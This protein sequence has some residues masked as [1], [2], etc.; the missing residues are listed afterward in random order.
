MNNLLFELKRSLVELDLGLKGDLG[1]SEAMEALMYSLFDDKV[2]AKWNKV[3]Y[4]SMRGLTTWLADALARQRQLEAWTADLALPKVTWLAGFFNAQAFLTAVMQVTARRNELPLDRLTTITDVTKKMTADE[5]ESISRDGAY[6]SGLFM[7]G[8]R[9]DTG[10]GQIE[11]AILKQL[12]SPSALATSRSFPPLTC[13]V[14][15]CSPADTLL[16]S[17]PPVL[18]SSR[19]P[20]IPS[21][22]HPV[23]PSPFIPSSHHPSSR[24]QKVQTPPLTPHV[25]P[26][27]PSRS[28]GHPRESGHGRQGRPRQLRVP[29]V[30]D[31]HAQ[32]RR[33]QA[34]RRLHLYR[35]PEDQAAGKQVVRESDASFQTRAPFAR[36]LILNPYV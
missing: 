32:P 12:Y 36:C 28:A 16:F 35:G 8:A 30:Q 27:L 26:P 1:M 5:I 29:R 10:T 7:E 15:P 19:H 22:R 13:P 11:D 24:E 9:W 17:R 2:P 25:R 3:A 20:V 23:I 33:R 31:S 34:H 18:P 4:P 14:H 21:S 6:V